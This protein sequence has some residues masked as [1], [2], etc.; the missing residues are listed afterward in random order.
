MEERRSIGSMFFSLMTKA[1][2]CAV[3]AMSIVGRFANNEATLLTSPMVEYGIAYAT[4]FQLLAL[5]AANAGI[6]VFI[7]HSK[8]MKKMRGIVQM[9]LVMSMCLAASSGLLVAF[10]WITGDSFSGWALFITLF[11]VV[12]VIA[13]IIMIIKT[14]SDDRKYNQLLD[15]Y[16]R[17]QEEIK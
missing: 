13:A 15:E 6:S 1:F 2:T 8:F 17:K 9:L 4:I 5:A 3:L 12:F 16:K 11:I 14:K 10:G 7:T